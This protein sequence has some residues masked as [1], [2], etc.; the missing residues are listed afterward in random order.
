MA[1]DRIEKH[2]SDLITQAQK[3]IE[4]DNITR[5][6]ISSLDAIQADILRLQASKLD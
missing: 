3:S 6:N 1:Y 4:L 5:N 2:T